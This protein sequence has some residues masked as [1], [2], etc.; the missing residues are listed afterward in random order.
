MGKLVD[1]TVVAILFVATIAYISFIGFIGIRSQNMPCVNGVP[2]GDCNLGCQLVSLFAQ[3]CGPLSLNEVGDFFAGFFAP[4]AVIWFA[5]AFIWQAR[6]LRLQRQEYSETRKVSEAQ[7]A[8]SE[9]RRIEEREAAES[10]LRTAKSLSGLKTL[11]IIL[12]DLKSTYEASTNELT[13]DPLEDTCRTLEYIRSSLE[14]M[15]APT[16]RVKR[17]ELIDVFG[18]QHEGL[19]SAT[20]TLKESLD[21]RSGSDTAVRISRLERVQQDILAI[22]SRVHSR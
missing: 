18:R 9:A 14:T 12:S 15:T 6:E 5:I 8:L 10:Q 20:A 4:L 1:Y 19:R 13:G 21:P 7:L 17:Q 11:Q 2:S 3:K 16:E 22:R